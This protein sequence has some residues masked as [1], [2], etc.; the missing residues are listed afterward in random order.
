MP[1]RQAGIP[2]AADTLHRLHPGQ[3]LTLLRAGGI[4]LHAPSATP[5]E[6]DLGDGHLVNLTTVSSVPRAFL[7]RNFL[8]PGE[9]EH[10]KQQAP[11]LCVNP[12]LTLFQPCFSPCFTPRRQAKPQME[13]AGVHF[14]ENEE[15]RGAAV[16]VR[17]STN[18]FL[19]A[20]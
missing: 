12:V 4:F 19:G 8:K 11:P 6:L 9:A 18:T 10:I 13:R 5:R 3:R 16:N 17:T 15:N 14:Y 1:M 20:V 7:I 2:V